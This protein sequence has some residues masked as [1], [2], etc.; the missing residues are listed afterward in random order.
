[1]TDPTNNHNSRNS[2]RVIGFNRKLS[3][4]QEVTIP[5]LL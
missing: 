5:V 4:A 3:E 2:V 1:M